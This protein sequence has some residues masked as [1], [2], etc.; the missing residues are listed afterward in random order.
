[1][2]RFVALLA[3]GE[4][5]VVDRDAGTAET[6]RMDGTGQSGHLLHSS[7]LALGSRPAL[8]L[9]DGHGRHFRA[10]LPMVVAVMN[11]DGE[12]QW[13]RGHPQ[14]HVP[15]RPGDG[16][17]VV[18]GEDHRLYVVDSAGAQLTVIVPPGGDGRVAYGS[19]VDGEVDGGSVTVP[20]VDEAGSRERS[21]RLLVHVDRDALADDDL[22]DVADSWGAVS[23]RGMQQVAVL[24]EDAAFMPDD[25]GS[26]YTAWTGEYADLDTMPGS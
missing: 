6:L 12:W 23:P 18:I 2:S 26:D 21:L 13:L 5:L 3:S 14:R 25:P 16:R 19:P 24:A 8:I 11:P 20:I 15:P 10:A 17:W 4:M 22:I 9:T 7:G 1:M